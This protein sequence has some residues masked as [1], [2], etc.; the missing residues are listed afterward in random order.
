MHLVGKIL[1]WLGY[2]V[3][4]LI[5]AGALY[6]KIGLALDAKLAPPASEMVGVDGRAIHVVC[7][8]D[9]ARTYLL[10]AG[11]GAWS[12][13]FWSLQPLLAKSAR[14]CAFDRPGLG[15]SDTMPGGHDVVSAADQ[16][17]KIVHAAKIPTPFIYVGHSLGANIAEIYHAKYGQD[18]AALVLIEPGFPPWLLE[19]YHGTSE[20]A[21]AM[22]DCD[23]KCPAAL[24]AGTLGI[25]R[26]GAQIAL[27][28][29]SLRADIKAQYQAGLG[30]SRTVA[31]LVAVLYGLPKIAYQVADLAG[32]GDT[33]VLTLASS[34]PV[35]P[36]KGESEDHYKKHMAEEWDYL[37]ALAAK[38][39]H[40][41]G[42]IVIPNSNHGNM[43]IGQTQSGATAR[44]ILDF[45][46]KELP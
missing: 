5:V 16:I 18:V 26:L 44:A 9:G 1:K 37:T 13:E 33:P 39:T 43:V 32:F 21:L 25:P 42:V 20:E 10:D 46:A 8:G 3:L 29:S 34:R 6:Q 14:V 24:V 28:H 19:D 41:T 12:W 30:R 38:S 4:G 22:P 11:A 35:E 17:F 40:G 23:W 15:W 31:T 27:G 7:T 45:V 2:F 36:D